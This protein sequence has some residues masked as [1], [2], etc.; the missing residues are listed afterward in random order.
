MFI[1]LLDL[2]PNSAPFSIEILV[3]K[4]VMGDILI[5]KNHSQADIPGID[6]IQ[7]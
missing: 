1:T 5:L 4:K 7:Y 3:G 6:C 2:A